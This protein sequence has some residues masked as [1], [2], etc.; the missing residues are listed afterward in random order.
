M[1]VEVMTRMSGQNA[2]GKN[3]RWND[4]VCGALAQH[5]QA[6]PPPL[7]DRG[8]LL[9]SSRVENDD[10]PAALPALLPAAFLFDAAAARRAGART[11]RPDFAQASASAIASAEGGPFAASSASS[12]ASRRAIRDCRSSS[13]RTA[14]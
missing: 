1:H 10:Q 2:L 7:V 4:E 14:R 9:D 6:R 5:A 12:H 8:Q 3:R 11:A 13:S